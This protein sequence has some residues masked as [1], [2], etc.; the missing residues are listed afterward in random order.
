MEAIKIDKNS[1]HYKI[2]KIVADYPNDIC[3]YRTA[4]MK[5]SF[6]LLIRAILAFGALTLIVHAVIG[7]A[8]ALFYGYGILT[9]LSIFGLI[10]IVSFLL[11]FVLVSLSMWRSKVRRA[12]GNQGPS[13]V[14]QAYRSW[15]EKHCAP[16]IIE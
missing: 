2:A 14:T 3:A 15:K 8:F 13:V 10:V 4:F 9:E 5:A 6:L 1:W 7:F 11:L 16:V 12:R